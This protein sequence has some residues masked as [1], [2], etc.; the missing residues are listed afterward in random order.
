MPRWIK[1]SLKVL[2]CLLAVVFV[3]WAALAIYVS[4]NEKK[5]TESITRQINESIS[6]E[7]KIGSMET[8]L[9]RGFPFASLSLRDVLIRDS[10]WHM[11]RRD[12]LNAK[13]LF[14]KLNVLSLLKSAPQIHTIYVNTATAALFVDTTGYTNLSAFSS[15]G[16]DST[17]NKKEKPHINNIVFNDVVV[18]FEEQSK[19]KLFQ[20]NI[21]DLDADLSYSPTGWSGVFKI[22]TL[23]KHMA[24]NMDKGSFLKDKVLRTNVRV[25]YDDV[26]RIM[27]IPVQDFRIG[28][29]KYRIGGR[30]N[31]QGKPTSFE[32]N[33]IGES[34]KYRN[35]TALLSS[36]ISSKLNALDF[37]KP[38][39]ARASI[40]GHI[41]YRD[42]PTVRVD[43]TIANNTLSVPDATLK[44]IS[45]KGYFINEVVKD[46]G[47]SDRNSAINVFGMKADWEDIPITADTVRVYN[48]IEPILEGRFR[49]QFALTKL[50]DAI[51]SRSFHF[52]N[53]S[54]NVNLLCR[55]GLKKD[56]TSRKYIYGTIKVDK[57]AMTYVPRSLKLNNC[58]ALLRFTGDDLLMQKVNLQTASTN[59]HMDGRIANFANLYYNDP[60]KILLD[61]HISSPQINLNEFLSFV[62]KRGGS[63]KDNMIGPSQQ[64]AKN[65]ANGNRRNIATRLDRVMDESSVHMKMEVGRLLYRR[66]KAEQI[67][68][69]INLNQKGIDIQ[70]LVLN[71]ADGRIKAHGTIQQSSNNR[72]DIKTDMENVDVRELFYSFENF[73]QDAITTE[74]IKGRLNTSVDIHGNMRDNGQIVPKSMHGTVDF[75]LQNGRLIN[76]EPFGKLAR[77][78]FRKRNLSDIELRK[79]ENTLEIKGDKIHIRPMT[80]ESSAIN[81]FVRGVYG[82][83]TGT[84][85]EIDVP[86]RN[87]KKDEL[88]ADPDEKQEKMRKGIVLYLKAIDGEDGKVKI[89]WNKKEERTQHVE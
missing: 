35:I 8:S 26:K 22:N 85:I 3:L 17:K 43:Y 76:F 6:G 88:I 32:L 66:F 25:S 30:F 36:S 28:E 15:S 64:P 84:H 34:I 39:S 44:N 14:V 61:W 27:D 50:N 33:I 65:E 53:G 57:A 1:I 21:R 45:F 4:R 40:I 48:L 12:L 77:F 86:L 59:L 5:I 67:S 18:R 23:V 29:D 52:T 10:L 72:F 73:G 87:P 38:V 55:A 71:H 24:F 82:I 63:S 46:G 83:P 60:G 31:L 41:K 89:Q 13:E 47:H 56:D 58:D 80:I 81:L 78:I 20:L 7:V 68:S 51:G 19:A 42:T 16:K 2:G 54:A 37:T 75:D 49:S 79:L 69:E 11:H 9:F 70:H 74:N 62:G